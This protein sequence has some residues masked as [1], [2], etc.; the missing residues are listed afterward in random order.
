MVSEQSP[1][2]PSSTQAEESHRETEALTMLTSE[3]MVTS[4]HPPI[5]LGK[6]RRV[7]HRLQFS[8]AWQCCRDGA[9]IL[10]VEP[11][12]PLGVSGASGLPFQFW[13]LCSIITP[14]KSS[15]S[16]SRTHSRPQW[17]FPP[18]A[19]PYTQVTHGLDSTF[20]PKPSWVQLCRTLTC[21]H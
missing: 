3:A 18:K 19:R 21:H 17:F 6:W 11:A 7:P 9:R 20:T 12:C 4:P 5:F 15:Q 13:M 16:L 8:S 14:Q 1:R 2:N 10:K